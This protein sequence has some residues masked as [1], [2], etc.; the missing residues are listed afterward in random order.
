M[1]STEGA[2]GCAPNQAGTCG[3]GAGSPD[4]AA[5]AR[6]WRGGMASLSTSIMPPAYLSAMARA[7]A[8]I[9][10]ERTGSGDTTFSMKASFFS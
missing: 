10:G 5:S 8:A 7:R 6:A 3:S 4:A 2:A 1:G 9:S